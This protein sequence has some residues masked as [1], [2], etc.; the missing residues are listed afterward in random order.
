MRAW[1]F[2]R[3]A[4]GLGRGAEVVGLRFFSM[5]PAIERHCAARIV[6]GSE[7]MSLKNERHV[8]I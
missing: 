2:G 7:V 6:D 3:E 4:A 1:S 8:D 5:P